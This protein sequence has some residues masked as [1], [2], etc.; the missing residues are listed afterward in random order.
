MRLLALALLCISNFAVGDDHELLTPDSLEWRPVPP[1]WFVGKIP[2]GAPPVR[3]EYAIIHG[4]P[5]KAGPFI[6]R[7]KSPPNS[8]L[9]VHWHKFDEH[10][11]VL[12]GVWCVGQTEKIDPAAC[13]DMPAGSYLFIPR[14]MHHWA[15]T[16]NSIVEVHGVGPFRA[17]VVQ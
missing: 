5:N 6:I 13:K 3:T 11:T 16:K 2:A 14:R 1:V 4:D 10:I 15:L 17:Y 7:L 9:P 8:I 12:S